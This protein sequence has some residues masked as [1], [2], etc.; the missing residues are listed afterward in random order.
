[1]GILYSILSKRFNEYA[2]S[3]LCLTSSIIQT[4]PI[5]IYSSIFDYLF[6]LACPHG[7]QCFTGSGKTGRKIDNEGFCN[8]FCRTYGYNSNKIFEG[9]GQLTNNYGAIDCR[10][11]I[12]REKDLG[13][14]ILQ[15][16]YR[17]IITIKCFV[18]ILL[19]FN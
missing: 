4:L 10:G 6:I 8:N 18:H 14:K 16:C 9:C 17:Y 7:C 12:N 15:F 13:K 3:I 19:K 2:K 1:M 11:C 5:F